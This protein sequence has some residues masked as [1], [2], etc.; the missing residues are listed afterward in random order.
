[1]HAFGAVKTDELRGGKVENGM[2]RGKMTR[3]FS[4]KDSVNT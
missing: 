4:K 1:M 2:Q 3:G